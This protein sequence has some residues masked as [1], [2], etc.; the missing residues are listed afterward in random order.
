V[1]P[2]YVVAD[3]LQRL[4]HGGLADGFD[5]QIGAVERDLRR[6]LA[7]APGHTLH[8]ILRLG[9]PKSAPV[10]SRRLPLA[11]VFADRSAA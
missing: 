9:Y 6:L 1:H 7:L 11:A 4:H 3:Q 5:A 8:M 2:Y 10:R